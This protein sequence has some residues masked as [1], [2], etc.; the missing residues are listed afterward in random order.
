MARRIGQIAVV[1]AVALV[2][3]GAVA[4]PAEARRRMAENAA[5]HAIGLCF[6]NGGNPDA[7]T[8]GGTIYVSCAWEDGSVDTLE[9]SDD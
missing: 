6:V 3:A 8:Y 4:S 7:Y 1:G 2:L 5:N 9:F